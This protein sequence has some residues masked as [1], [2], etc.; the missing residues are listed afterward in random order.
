[1]RAL[2]PET[3]GLGFGHGLRGR[4]FGLHLGLEAL[5]VGLGLGIAVPGLGLGVVPCGLVTITITN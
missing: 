5:V 1:V 2:Q 4:I 3:L